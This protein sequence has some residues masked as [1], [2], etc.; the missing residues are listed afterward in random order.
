MRSFENELK[1]LRRDFHKYAE[2]MWKEYRT[3]SVVAKHLMALDIPI[4][5]GDN[6]SQKGMQFQYPNNEVIK[7]EKAR[8]ISQGADPVLIEQMDD[9]PGVIGIIDT[10]IP[11]PITAFRF[12][13]DALPFTETKD[14]Q[15][16]P[17]RENFVSVNENSCHACGHDGHTAIGMC[18]ATELAKIQDTLCGKIKLIFQ[19]AE[20]GGGGA[21]GIVARGWLDDVN[22]F[23]AG[24][25]GLTKLDGLP[26]GSHGL[27]GGTKDFLDNRRYNIIYKGV[28]AHPCGN[29]NDGKNALLAACMAALGVHTIPP[30]SQGEFHQ[31]VG[32]LRAGSSR[33]TIAS[34]AYMEIEIRGENDIVAE[35]GEQRMLSVVEGAAKVYDVK[36][37]TILIGKTAA[38]A[39]DDKAIDIVIKCAKTIPWFTELHSIGSVG[40]SD[41]ASEMLRRV[42]EHGGIGTYIGLGA[43]FKSSFHDK[44]FDFDENILAPAVELFIKITKELHTANSK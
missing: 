29:P 13:I 36:C 4:V 21:R 34:D 40:G 1:K 7:K 31:N 42:Q 39:S 25:V 10:G 38:G 9:L 27:I 20:E 11:G 15:H 6:L 41:D 18:V 14:H 8:A 28:A 26:L 43:D 35:Y 23:F 44:A 33:N 2:S 22:Y 5:L 17:V 24:H 37:E 30:H 32:I 19:P 12:D 16:R 3:T